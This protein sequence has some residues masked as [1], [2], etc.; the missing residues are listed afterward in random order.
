MFG[1]VPK[2]YV[3][4]VSR[5]VMPKSAAP[6]SPES[7][8]N[9]IVLYYTYIMEIGRASALRLLRDHMPRLSHDNIELYK[10]SIPA[11]VSLRVCSGPR[12][13]RVVS[14]Y[15]SRGNSNNIICNRS[16]SKANENQ[17]QAST[18]QSE[19]LVTAHVLYYFIIPGKLEDN[20]MSVTYLL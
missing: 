9:A 16:K 19:L 5:K 20:T 11:F 3:R 6:V 10:V 15:Q 12:Q 8:S 4:G 18:F 13:T 17:F 7:R 2:R 1:K 14:C